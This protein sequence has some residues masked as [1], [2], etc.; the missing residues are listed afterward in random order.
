MKNQYII[1]IERNG[2]A[3][4][5]YTTTDKQNVHDAWGDDWNDRPYEHNAG[6]VYDRYVNGLVDIYLDF[7]YNIFEPQDMWDYKG[8]SPYSKEDF[9]QNVVPAAIITGQSL[10]DVHDDEDDDEGDVYKRLASNSV[11][12]GVY[13]GQTV[14]ALLNALNTSNIAVIAVKHKNI[15]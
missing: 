6:L 3:L 5:L 9:K 8:N 15:D 14:D 2:A 13:H 4:R 11:N 1:D 7:E 12:V 10:W